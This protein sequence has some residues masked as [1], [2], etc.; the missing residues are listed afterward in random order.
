[1]ISHSFTPLLPQV[2]VL[3]YHI[4]CSHSLRLWRPH[5]LL[6]RPD[7][8]QFP[9]CPALITVMCT[10]PLLPR[11]SCISHGSALSTATSFL[12][13]EEITIVFSS[14]FTYITHLD[15]RIPRAIAVVGT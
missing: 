8:S 13:D 10:V 6:E 11:G 12:L 5:Q 2:H 15:T 4:P 7:C 14:T 1:M 3:C 9:R